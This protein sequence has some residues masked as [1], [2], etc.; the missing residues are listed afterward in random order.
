MD[1][2]SVGFIVAV[3]LSDFN[4]AVVVLNDDEK[5]WVFRGEGAGKKNG[6]LKGKSHEGNLVR[7][8]RERWRGFA[9][10][11]SSNRTCL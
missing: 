10:P 2:R 7:K 3:L 5:V 8:H 9:D 11:Y 6:S 4:S 1:L